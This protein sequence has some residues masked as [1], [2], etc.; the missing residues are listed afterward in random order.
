[1]EYAEALAKISALDG[2]AEFAAAVK[3]KV[4]ALNDEAAGHRVKA[5]GAAGRLESL[6]KAIGID[7]NAEDLLAALETVNKDRPA[8]GTLKAL[9]A[10]LAALT[11]TVESERAGKAQE[12]TR[13]REL[14]A[15]QS[16][17]EA[18]SKANAVDPDELSPLVLASIVVGDD[19]NP[20]WKN[21]D[22][23]FSPV[24]D[25]VKNW[26]GSK[27]HFVKSNQQG[28]PGGGSA[29]GTSHGQDLSKLNVTDRI[30]LGLKSST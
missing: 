15:K 7:P 9:E 11:R 25:G 3:A 8:P 29:Q 24:A 26:I 28:G 13:R 19:D 16:A 18:L 27:P 2:G 10:Q 4:S 1:M 6:A 30:A 20:Q 21:P 17:R 12:V 23:T 14:L 5:S 22:G